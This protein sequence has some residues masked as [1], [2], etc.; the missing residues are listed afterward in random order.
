MPQTRFTAPILSATYGALCKELDRLESLGIL[1]KVNHADW[2]T[3]IVP[4]PKKD[5]SIRICG[6]YKVTP[7]PAL[8]IDQYPLPKPS[9]LMTC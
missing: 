2:A 5:E 7:N 1:C 6:D 8:L 9:D 3:P 4:V